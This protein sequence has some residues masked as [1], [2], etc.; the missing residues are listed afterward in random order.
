ME[1]QG[2]HVIRSS[3]AQNTRSVLCM[4]LRISLTSKPEY[5]HT[6]QHVA[7]SFGLLARLDYSLVCGA[8]CHFLEYNVAPC[9]DANVKH[10]KASVPHRL[11]LIVFFL[12]EIHW[13]RIARHTLDRL[14][15]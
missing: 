5:Y 7:T 8:L 2:S 14:K 10:A 11:Q 12:K 4:L 3:F 9:F 15:L 1:R 6:G 13:H